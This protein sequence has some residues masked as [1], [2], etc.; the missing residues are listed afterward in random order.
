MKKTILFTMI[1]GIML[2]VMKVSAA[3]MHPRAVY[4]GSVC[5]PDSPTSLPH[6][7]H[8]SVGTFNL[9]ASGALRS[10]SCPVIRHNSHNSNGLPS[11]QVRVETNHTLDV[12]RNPLDC[13]LYSRD[14]FGNRVGGTPP[15]RVQDSFIHTKT[16]RENHL[17]VARQSAP[18]GYYELTC[19]LPYQGG[20]ISIQITEHP[21]PI[22]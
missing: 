13:E 18:A 14:L 1:M 19:K 2:S 15:R 20:I 8:R 22:N 17:L 10:V 9:D 16:G 11:V 4:P 12:R 7:V 5:Q 3:E 6:I 21:I